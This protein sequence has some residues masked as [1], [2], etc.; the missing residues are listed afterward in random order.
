MTCFNVKLTLSNCV[1]ASPLEA[2]AIEGLS[3]LR[4]PAEQLAAGA[5]RVQ[6]EVTAT[7]GVTTEVTATF[8][9]QAAAEQTC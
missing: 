5:G 2:R 1:S 4:G 9:N 7:S 6:T 3:W 8:Y